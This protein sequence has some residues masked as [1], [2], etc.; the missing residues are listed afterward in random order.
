MKHTFLFLM[1]YLFIITASAQTITVHGKLVSSDNNG[2]PY[3][4]I[5]VAK[6]ST[7][8]VNLKKLA[9]KENGTFTTAL[10]Q[11]AYIF[12]FN[13]VGMDEVV[14]S[15]E[16]TDSDKTLDMGV[17]TM[18]ESSTELDELSVT[19]QRPLVKVE[20]DKLQK[21][22][23]NHQHQMYSICYVKCLLLLLMARMKF[24]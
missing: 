14:E 17:I 19:A 9:T 1:S 3:A 20:I 22:I 5:S 23:L 2:L 15:V 21:M 10:E 13:F 12:T 8:N 24:S 4:T 18:I 16:I 11:G 7:P 6:S